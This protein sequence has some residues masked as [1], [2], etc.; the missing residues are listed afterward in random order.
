MKKIILFLFIILTIL[1]AGNEITI[2]YSA[3]KS[4]IKYAKKINKKN[5]RKENWKKYKIRNAV[6]LTL[7]SLTP[8]GYCFVRNIQDQRK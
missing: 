3:N 7:I 8:L 6:F 5:Y 4:Y 2:D 1:S